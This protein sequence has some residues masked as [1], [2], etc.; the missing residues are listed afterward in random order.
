M[1]QI[2]ASVLDN[3]VRDWMNNASQ[4]IEA[5]RVRLRATAGAQVGADRVITLRA[6][7]YAGQAVSGR[8]LV[9][10]YFSASADGA[11]GGTQ[12]VTWGTGEVLATY[13]A[14]ESYLVLTEADGTASLTVNGAAGNRRVCSAVIGDVSIGNAVSWT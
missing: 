3:E 13:T 14:N 6:V 11:P 5:A 10:V 1:P 12:T 8:W 9:F 4:R 7:D 2:P